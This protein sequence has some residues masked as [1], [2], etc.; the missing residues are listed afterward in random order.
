MLLQRMIKVGLKVQHLVILRF[1]V[2]TMCYKYEAKRKVKE[3]MQNLIC[4]F[5]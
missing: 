2:H 4:D 5:I 3:E 1:L